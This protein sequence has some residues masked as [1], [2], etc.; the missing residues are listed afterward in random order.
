M[1]SVFSINHLSARGPCNLRTKVFFVHGKK[2]SGNQGKT[3][4]FHKSL[5]FRALLDTISN[6]FH[7]ARWGEQASLLEL[8]VLHPQSW[9][10]SCHSCTKSHILPQYPLSYHCVWKQIPSWKG[11]AWLTVIFWDFILVWN[12]LELFP[13]HPR[14]SPSTFWNWFFSRFLFD[15]HLG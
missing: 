8:M 13:K 14:H 15:S 1:F 3:T 2:V 9:D 12:Y 6:D 7:H 10:D 11:L 5:V 4:I